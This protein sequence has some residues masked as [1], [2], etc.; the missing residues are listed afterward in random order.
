MPRSFTGWLKD[1]IEE[2]EEKEREAKKQGYTDQFRYKGRG[3]AFEQA[4]A[5]FEKWSK[6]QLEDE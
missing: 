5:A 3:E 4:L 6:N 2:S 1:R